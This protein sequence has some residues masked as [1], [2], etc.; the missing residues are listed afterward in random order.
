MED[1]FDI[2]ESAKYRDFDSKPFDNEPY[3]SSVKSFDTD[4]LLDDQPSLDE[5]NPP[6]YD[7]PKYRS[8]SAV[9]ASHYEYN[10][11][12]GVNEKRSAEI[13]LKPQLKPNVSHGNK[14]Q[15][16][17]PDDNHVINYCISKDSSRCDE[18]GSPCAPEKPFLLMPTHLET[19]Q[20][21]DRVLSLVET[22]LSSAPE[23]SFEFNSKNFVVRFSL[24]IL[25]KVQL[26]YLAYDFINIIIFL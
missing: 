8:I 10:V 26:S 15:K 7:I 1:T 4:F 12:V 16:S 25:C 23:V 3:R 19:S 5:V 13:L 14:T 24:N 17:D 6:F 22:A 18:H 2:S 21:L 9:P 20:S 11:P